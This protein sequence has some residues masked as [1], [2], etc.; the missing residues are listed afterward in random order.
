MAETDTS[1][2]CCL[3]RNTCTKCFHHFKLVDHY[4]FKLVDRTNR[5]GMIDLKMFL[6]PSVKVSKMNI[7][8][9]DQQVHFKHDA[10]KQ[11]RSTSTPPTQGRHSCEVTLIIRLAFT[12]ML[13][14]TGHGSQLRRLWSL[15]D[16]N[17]NAPLRTPMMRRSFPWYSSPICLHSGPCARE[18]REA[19]AEH[20][21][22]RRKA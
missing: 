13:C 14:H 10:W 20:H 15:P 16:V 2:T 6:S 5:P 12:K 11:D 1:S 3:P 18:S 22:M 17:M 7:V 21:Q 9:S 19:S 4:Q 8:F